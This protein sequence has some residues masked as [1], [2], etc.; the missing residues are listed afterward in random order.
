MGYREPRVFANLTAIDTD[1]EGLELRV[2]KTAKLQLFLDLQT[3]D[4][5]DSMDVFG[6]IILDSWNLEDADTGE[7]IPPT[8][9]GMR[10]ISPDLARW[11]IERWIEEVATVSSPLSR[12]SG[13]GSPSEEEL[14]AL[15]S[16]SE[17]LTPSS[18]QN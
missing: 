1:Y 4:G 14:T 17:S 13:N 2:L 15:A 7:P 3:M 10:Q 12:P 8:G 11:I 16:L 18:E 6:D 5:M 9:A